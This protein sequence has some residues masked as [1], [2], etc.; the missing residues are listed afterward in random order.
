M[1]FENKKTHL[2]PF[3]DRG[4]RG[5]HESGH[6]L[7]EAKRL[8]GGLTQMGWNGLRRLLNAP[9]DAFLD[10]KKNTEARVKELHG[11]R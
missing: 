10:A 1:F 7:M 11:E 3:Q 5:A 6:G 2:P 9:C 4:V 8:E